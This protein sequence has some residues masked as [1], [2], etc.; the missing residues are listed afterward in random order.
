[1]QKSYEGLDEL[2]TFVSK[3]YSDKELFQLGSGENIPEKFMF[4]T[5]PY[6]R[7]VMMMYYKTYELNLKYL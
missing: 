1:M 4:R 5:N 2:I 3:F 7:S 6:F